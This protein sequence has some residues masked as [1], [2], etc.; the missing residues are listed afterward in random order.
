MRAV[1]APKFTDPS[2]YEL[3]EVEAPTV[4]QPTDV[5]VQIHAA[6]IN[7]VDVKLA[8]GAFKIALSEEYVHIQ[9]QA[10]LYPARLRHRH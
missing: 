6:S 7:P 1:T 9:P 3:S 5:I 10:I 4:S 8:A 2:G